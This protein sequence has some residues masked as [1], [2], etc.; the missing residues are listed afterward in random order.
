MTETAAFSVLPLGTG[1]FF[2]TQRYCSSL[3]LMTASSRV[4]IDCPDPLY[5][6]C[7][8]AARAS[9]LEVDPATFDHI[10]ITHIHGDHCNGLEGFG[11]FRKF[12]AERKVRPTLH[13]T[14]AVAEVLWNKLSP[15]MGESIESDGTKTRFELS[16]YFDLKV[17]DFGES[18]ETGDIQFET[19][20]TRHSVPSVALLATHGG[21]CFGYSCD[22]SF[23]PELIAFLESADLIFHET[24]YGDMHTPLEKLEQLPPDLRAKM[25]LIHLGDEFTASK[26]I[27][28]AREG[29]L[30]KV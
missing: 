21:R 18:F 15:A 20:R 13:T 16:E 12:V 24:D 11:F 25:R 6:M 1:N 4:L 3:L 23:D 14:P 5:R 27:E 29:K 2:S 10:I 22:T 19:R 17:F 7:A 9:G 28:A 8:D 26:R 30:Y